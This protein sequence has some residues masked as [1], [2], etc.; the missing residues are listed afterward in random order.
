M[1]LDV[2]AEQVQ[3]RGAQVATHGHACRPAAAISPTSVVTVLF[4]LEPLIATMG[5]FALRANRS[6]SPDSFHPTGS[7]RLQRRRRQGQAG[8]H[9]ELIGAARGSARP[10]RATH[11]HLRIVTA[12]RGRLRWIFPRVRYGKRHTPARQKA[13]QGHAALAEADNDAEVVRSD[14]RHRFYL[15]FSVARPIS[16]RSR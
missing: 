3:R 7:G 10:A 2:I 12:Q 8:A 14:Q 15:S 9:A 11:V 6:M 16:M 4:A 5:A 1:Q 13:H